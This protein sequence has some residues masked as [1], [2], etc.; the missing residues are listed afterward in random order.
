LG[1]KRVNRSPDGLNAHN[2]YD[3]PNDFTQF[4][5]RLFWVNSLYSFFR[6]GLPV[7]VSDIPANKE[8]ALPEERY[9]R[10]ELRD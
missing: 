4:S 3:N 2:D 10:T 1:K 7:L 5:S 6:Y 8:V 9:L